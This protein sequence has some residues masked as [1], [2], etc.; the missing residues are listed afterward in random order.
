MAR[1]DVGW[2]RGWVT[3]D[4]QAPAHVVAGAGGAGQERG[5]GL[6]VAD[7]LAVV[8][9]LATPGVGVVHALDS[10]DVGR[11][12]R[13][14]FLLGGAEAIAVEFAGLRRCVAGGRPRRGRSRRR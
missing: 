9:E 3:P 6:V 11:F 2:Q 7:V 10:T 5:V 14:D 8:V 13:P 4:G 12:A 1:A